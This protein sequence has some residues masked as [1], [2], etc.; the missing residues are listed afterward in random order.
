MTSMVERRY[1]RSPYLVMTWSGDDTVLL[2]SDTL[3]RYRLSPKLIPVLSRLHEW[4]A[5]S[6]PALA[7][8]AVGGAELEQ[9]HRMGILQAEEEADDEQHFAWDPLELAVHRLTAEGGRRPDLLAAG[10]P[11]RHAER[12]HGCASTVLP[13]AASVLAG[14]LGEMLRRRRSVRRYADRPL[15]LAELS[16]LL[17]HAARIERLTPS[18][19]FGDRALRPFPTGGARSEL[20]IYVLGGGVAGLRAGAH[21]YDA[22]AHRLVE[23]RPADDHQ[24]GIVRAVH[25]ATGGQLNRD[26]AVILLVTAVFERVMWKYRHLGLSLVYKD[27]GGLFQTLYLVATALGLAPCAIGGGD[28]AANSRWLGLNPLCESQVGCFLIGPAEV[29]P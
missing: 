15:E 21:Y 6:D 3:R 23:V 2:H 14:S 29:A 27:V 8:S 7:G 20:E 10:P 16:M 1:R 5:A 13:E 19:Q 22:G 24:A 11:P 26:P 18:A 9:L 25:A 28:E 4:T 17:H 12:L